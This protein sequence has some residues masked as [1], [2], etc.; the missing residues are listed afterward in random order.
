MVGARMQNGGLAEYDEGYLKTI[1]NICSCRDI[2]VSPDV[3]VSAVNIEY[4]HDFLEK[5]PAADMVVFSYIF[6][7]PSLIGVHRVQDYVRQSAKALKGETWHD[8]LMQ[9]GARVAFNIFAD[10]GQCE[11]PTDFLAQ[12]PFSRAGTF[13]S[14]GSN[15]NYDLLMR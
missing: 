1:F 10:H 11:L 2:A 12:A 4:G 9:T 6:Y 13:S 14:S 3:Q 8:A 7:E 15:H 5:P